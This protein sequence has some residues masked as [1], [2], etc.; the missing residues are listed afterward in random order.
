MNISRLALVTAFGLGLSSMACLGNTDPVAQPLDQD[1]EPPHFKTLA[2]PGG[3][4]STNGLLPSDFHA[5]KALLKTAV[6]S[7]LTTV[8]EL[9]VGTTIDNTELLNTP[10]GQDTF[11]YAVQCGFQDGKSFDDTNVPSRSYTG[12]ELLRSTGDW[13]TSTLLDVSAQGDIFACVMTHLNPFNVHP[14]I[15]LRGRAVRDQ[16]SPLNDSSLYTFREALWTASIASGA[17]TLHVWPMV[18]LKDACGLNPAGGEIAYESVLK[19]VCGLN[20]VDCGIEVEHD[21]DGDCVVSAEGHYTCKGM[22]AIQT[23]LNPADVSALHPGCIP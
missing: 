3:G 9:H 16:P 12:H 14:H 8:D 5:N 6:A 2:D 17:L 11:D 13:P 7:R 23:W 21:I 22:R 18:D 19:R 1:I 10:G 20:I 15:W 4:I